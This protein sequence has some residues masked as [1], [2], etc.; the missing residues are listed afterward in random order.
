M[1]FGAHLPLVDLGETAWSAEDLTRY[2]EVARDSGFTAIGAND[3][4]VFQRPWLD[5]LTALACVLERSA[6]MTLA[7]TIALPVVRGPVP[8]AK[9]AAALD[10]L[11]GG[12]LVLGVGPG[13][14]AADY[15]AVGVPFEERWPRFDEAVQVLRNS[16]AGAPAPGPGPYYESPELLPGPGRQVPIWIGSWGSPAGLR[17]VARLGDG[18][19]AS[20]YNS[21]P[22]ELSRRRRTLLATLRSEGRGAD[23]FPVVLATTWTYLTDSRSAARARIDALAALLRRDPVA[24]AEQVLVGSARSCVEKLARYA[25]AGVDTVFIWPLAEPTDQLR[26]FGREVA[27]RVPARP[28]G[29]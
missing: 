7:T 22:E 11:S 10:L 29:S 13:S 21:T 19:I 4:L 5:G 6:G 26:R 25:E 15:G 9:S 2:V 1:R 16:L 27:P 20:A 23:G 14:S 12:R 18:W 8:L 17:R 24:L 28:A 3:H